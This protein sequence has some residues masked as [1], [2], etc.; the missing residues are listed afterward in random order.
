MT[1]KAPARIEVNDTRALVGPALII[2]LPN[3]VPPRLIVCKS[4][5]P[6]R[7]ISVELVMVAPVS[8]IPTFVLRSA[9]RNF[10]LGIAT[11]VAP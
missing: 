5:V 11:V 1:S 7:V 8:V 2:T 10:R 9:V 6:V 3:S 4:A